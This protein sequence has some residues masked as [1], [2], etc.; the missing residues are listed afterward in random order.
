MSHTVC[1]P[2]TS[3]RGTALCVI[4]L[5]SEVIGDDEEVV[6]IALELD[7]PETR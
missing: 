7:S 4:V 6:D 5:G 1:A 2:V 3:C